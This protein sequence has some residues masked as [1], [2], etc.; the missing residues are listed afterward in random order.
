MTDPLQQQPRPAS[1]AAAV[2]DAVPVALTRNG[3]GPDAS[4]RLTY[5]EA[6]QPPCFSCTTSPCCTYLLLG[7]FRIETLLDIDHAV[8]LSNFEGIYLG[9]DRERKVDIYFHQPCGYLDVPSGLC[10]VHSTP[11]Q[12]AV[13]VQYNAHVC[14]YRHRMNADVDLDHPHLDARRVGWLAEH[15][16][17]DDDRRVVALPGWD[18]MLD[19]F[20]AMPLTRTPAAP[21]APDPIMEEWRSIAL[22]PKAPEGETRTLRRYGDPEV[23]D[24]CTGCGAWCCQTLIFNRGM[25]A[26]VSQLEFLRYCLGFPGVEVGVAADSWAVIVRT[27]C[28]HLEDNR[29]AVFGTGERPLKCGYY[30][31]VSCSYRRHFGDPRPPDI[32]RVSR[33]QFRLVMD[34]IIFNDLGRVV[35]IPPLDVLRNRLEAAER[36]TAGEVVGA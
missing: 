4:V 33:Q 20:R 21:P 16:V 6:L 31:A 5:R 25:P 28:R 15:T 9:L 34:S 22:S 8:Y 27:R 19:A 32:V 1:T 17:F 3:Q 23:S 26:D 7:D 10:T 36:T 11:V 30:D 2:T 13:C 18:D 29:C 24:P 14:G 35:A 12:P